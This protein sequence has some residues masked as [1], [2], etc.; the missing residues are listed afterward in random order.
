MQWPIGDRRLSYV[1]F[2]SH[3]RHEAPGDEPPLRR[4]PMSRPRPSAMPRSRSRLRCCRSTSPILMNFIPPATGDAFR[5]FVMTGTT[6]AGS[7]CRRLL[8]LMRLTDFMA[9][10]ARLLSL[11]GQIILAMLAHFVILRLLAQ[12]QFRHY[13]TAW[14]ISGFLAV[15]MNPYSCSTLAAGFSLLTGEAVGESRLRRDDC[16][17]LRSHHVTL[18]SRLTLSVRQYSLSGDAQRPCEARKL[19]RRSHERPLMVDT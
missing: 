13:R 17:A 11:S 7:R 18:M 14:R 3:L 16:R 1:C 6:I 10:A 8:I 4:L 9:S 19:R 15:L 12:M 2:D 5:P